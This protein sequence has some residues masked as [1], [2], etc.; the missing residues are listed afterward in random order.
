MKLAGRSDKVTLRVLDFIIKASDDPEE[1]ILRE[2]EEEVVCNG[3]ALDMDDVYDMLGVKK[4]ATGSF[5]EYANEVLNASLRI[6]KHAQRSDSMRKLPF[7]GATASDS[8][9]WLMGTAIGKRIEHLR[10]QYKVEAKNP[11]KKVL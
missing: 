1:K 7:I 9:S 6:D 10:E 3:E 4:S 11:E 8:Y 5:Q 2:I